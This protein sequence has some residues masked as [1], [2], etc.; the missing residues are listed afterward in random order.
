LAE[1]VRRYMKVKISSESTPYLKFGC[2]GLYLLS[3]FSSL[4][5]RQDY[6]ILQNDFLIVWFIG[7]LIIFFTFGNLKKI[8]LDS[9]HLYISNYIKSIRIPFSDVK[10]RPKF[11][12][13]PR[14]P[15]YLSLNV[16]TELGRHIT[17]IPDYDF[18]KKW[19]KET[20]PLINN[21]KVQIT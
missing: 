1:D 7:A 18:Y 6:L 21:F 11:I 19:R 12:M 3:F 4:P 5:N 14:F 20:D 9:E 16:K 10:K 13:S 8:E 17:F 15:T 2:S